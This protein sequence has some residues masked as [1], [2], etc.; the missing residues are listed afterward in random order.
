M[1]EL[2]VNHAGGVHGGIAG[3]YNRSELMAEH[4][5]ALERWAEHVAGLAAGRAAKVVPMRAA[6]E[7]VA[8]LDRCNAR[9]RAMSR[10]WSTNSTVR[11]GKR[12]QGQK[13][14]RRSL[15]LSFP[16]DSDEGAIAAAER[17]DIGPVA[18]AITH[19]WR[20]FYSRP[21]SSVASTTQGYAATTR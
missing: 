19:R 11:S 13:R 4:K 9:R 12:A 2:C 1:V 18:Q 16:E 3:V 17:G 14:A 15:P 8:A 5:A 10:G 7:Q 6:G 20:D 21:R